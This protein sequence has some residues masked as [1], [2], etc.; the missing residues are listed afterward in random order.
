MVLQL[1]LCCTLHIDSISCFSL[2][3]QMA[4]QKRRQEGSRTGVFMMV[5]SLEES[6]VMTRS[7]GG[8]H[9]AAEP[10]ASAGRRRKTLPFWSLGPFYSVWVGPSPAGFSCPSSKGVF[11]DENFPH[12]HTQRSVSMVILSPIQLKMKIND[13]SSHRDRH[14][15]L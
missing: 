12:K 8:G 2:V 1:R 14:L 9:K 13:Q 11:L 4:K 10:I 5:P 3:R 15:E 7:H 6:S